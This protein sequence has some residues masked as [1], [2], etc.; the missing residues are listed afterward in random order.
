MHS[1]NHRDG[2]PIIHTRPSPLQLEVHQ[3]DDKQRSP[4]DD[5]RTALLFFDTP[6]GIRLN[7]SS[8]TSANFAHTYTLGS[9]G[10]VDGSLS[11]LYTSLPIRHTPRS[12]AIDL[13]D[14]VIGY[15]HV[16]EL[17]KPEE[18]WSPSKWE[19]ALAGRKGN[20]HC[21]ILTWC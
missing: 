6:K 7:V 13:Q 18:I 4:A 17:Q 10:L 11:Y 5:T 15:R 14:V 16:R 19:R 21:N 1:G 3:A 9:V 8:L 12:A 20:S 2:I